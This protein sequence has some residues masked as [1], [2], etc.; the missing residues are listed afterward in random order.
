VASVRPT[1]P[2]PAV[3]NPLGSRMR[4]GPGSADPGEIDYTNVRL[5]E[6]LTRA[7][8]IKPYQL[9][10]P[11]WMDNERFDIVAKVP[12]GTTP[13]QFNTMLQ[14]LLIERFGMMVRRET[15]EIAGYELTV[16]RGGPKFKESAPAQA[17]AQAEGGNQ[18]ERVPL[19]ERAP[20]KA[21]KGKDGF[22]ELPP[23]R[24]NFAL[25]AF[26]GGVIKYS[27]RGQGISAICSRL[28]TPL[29]KPVMD[30]TGLD[31]TYDYNLSFTRDERTSTNVVGDPGPSTAAA[32]PASID[33]PPDLFTAIQDQLGLKLEQK[34][35]PMDIVIVDRAERTPKEN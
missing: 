13:E 25:F 3:P 24:N 6:L 18:K 20:L 31:G 9:S 7:Y 10:A 17:G 22:P 14:N 11:S 27:A 1:G 12:R 15:R 35:I 5:R 29:G 26:P 4:G 16:S 28:E 30:K 23:G 8:G 32:G 2:N 34:R 19:E 21:Q 33:A